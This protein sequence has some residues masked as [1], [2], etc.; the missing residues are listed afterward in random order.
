MVVSF[1]TMIQGIR[2]NAK[3]QRDHSRFKKI[4]M[5]KV[6]AKERQAC[7]NKRQYGTMNGTGNRSGNP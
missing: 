7:K 3:C 4:I 1:I 6:D 2:T 5:N